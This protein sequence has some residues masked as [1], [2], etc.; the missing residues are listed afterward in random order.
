MILITL[1]RN[2]I[3]LVIFLTGC[4]S[5]YRFGPKDKVDYAGY[6]YRKVYVTDKKLKIPGEIKKSFRNIEFCFK[7]DKSCVRVF[8]TDNQ[9]MNSLAFIDRETKNG[10][11]VRVFLLVAFDKDTN[12]DGIITPDDLSSIYAYQP[13]S[14]SLHLLQEGV[15]PLDYESNVDTLTFFIL[16]QKNEKPYITQYD[17]LDIKPI[18]TVER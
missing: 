1:K 9:Y 15:V 2:L 7:S 5:T 4:S 14:K 11:R 12:N 10:N 3:F 18:K 13:M 17:L 16:Y 8:E 6:S